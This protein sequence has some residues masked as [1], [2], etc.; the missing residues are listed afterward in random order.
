MTW[1]WVVIAFFTM[2][3]VA[4]LGEICS[5]YPTMGMYIYIYI[6]IYTAH[7]ICIIS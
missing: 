2:I 4:S 3:M 5:A 7:V 1:S 6:Y